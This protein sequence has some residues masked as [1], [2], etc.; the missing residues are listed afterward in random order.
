MPHPL[1]LP[2]TSAKS[3]GYH[4]LCLTWLQIEDSLDPLP[5]EFDNL[6]NSSQN[7]GEHFFA[8]TSLLKDMSSQK[9][10]YMSGSG[11][12]LS[13]ADSVSVEMGSGVG[14]HLPGMWIYLQVGSCLRE[15]PGLWG[16]LW[17]ILH[18]DMIHINFIF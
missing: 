16:L 6:L 12:V 13:A 18:I 2:N 4:S 10:K 9:K 15:I 1:Q 8:F 14:H 3:P 7:S 11:K 17:R 5:T